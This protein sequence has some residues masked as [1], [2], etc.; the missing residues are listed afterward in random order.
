MDKTDKVRELHDQ[1]VAGVEALVDSDRWRAFLAVAPR[2]HRYSPT[3]V[4]LILLQAPHATRVA[5]YRR[6][7]SL[8]RQV[9]KG[10]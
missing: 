1:L 9:P 3:N 6:W 8:G 4:L 10:A 2:F 7:Q 5:G